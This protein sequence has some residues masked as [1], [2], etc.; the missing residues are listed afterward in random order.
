M[1]FWFGFATVLDALGEDVPQHWEY[2]RGMV[3]DATVLESATEDW[4]A[5]EIM[6][7]LT[8]EHIT[9]ADIRWYGSVLARYAGLLK[10]AGRSY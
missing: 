9:A 5:C 7:L 8:A 4:P 3:S 6:E 1:M 10:D 2:R